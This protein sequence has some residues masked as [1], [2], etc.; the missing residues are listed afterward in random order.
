MTDTLEYMSK[1]TRADDRHKPRRLYALPEALADAVDK[2]AAEQFTNGTAIVR[3]AVIRYLK[4]IDR[5]PTPKK[6]QKPPK[7]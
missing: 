4:E 1:P 3:A 2:V 6:P 5:L 7:S